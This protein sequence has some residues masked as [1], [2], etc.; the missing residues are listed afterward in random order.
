VAAQLKWSKLT[1]HDAGYDDKRVFHAALRGQEAPVL[2]K[3]Q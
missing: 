3:Q 2:K 1:A